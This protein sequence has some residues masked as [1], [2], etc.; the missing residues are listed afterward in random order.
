M[1]WLHPRLEMLRRYAH[2][3]V[4][5]S[6]SRRLTRHLA[7]CPRCRADVMRL[8]EIR[9]LLRQDPPGS[10]PDVLA[11]VLARRAAGERLLIPDVISCESG[12][13]SMRM[14]AAAAA[15]ILACGAALVFVGSPV[16]G[17]APGELRFVPEAP[18]P[19]AEIEVS[20]RPGAALAHHDSVVLRGRLRTPADVAYG[21][22]D[23]QRRVAVLRRQ[24][25]GAFTGT[26]RLPDSV[27]YAVFAVEDA[28]GEVIDS[29]YRR[30]WELEVH[31]ADGRV[32]FE[33]LEQRYREMHGRSW[34]GM[35]ES[36]RS[37][38]EQY[39]ED[40]RGW[41]S[42]SLLDAKVAPQDGR[43]SDAVSDSLRRTHFHA[44]L[45]PQLS[46]SADV[47]D[48]MAGYAPGHMRPYWGERLLREAPLHPLSLLTRENR[49]WRERVDYPALV[50]AMWREAEAVIDPA[51]SPWIQNVA[52]RLGGTGDPQLALRW[53][54]RYL[55]ISGRSAANT[56]NQ[57]ERLARR[58]ELSETVLRMALEY[59]EWTY[60]AGDEF[61]ALHTPRS[62]FTRALARDR[63]STLGIAA[64][65]MLVLGDTAAALRTL[66]DATADGWN[67][68]A[69]ALAA[70]TLLATGDTLGAL[71]QWALAATEPGAEAYADTARI[72]G[73][74]HFAP[75]A[76]SEW[77]AGARERLRRVLYAES[78][79][80]EIW[81]SIVLTDLEGRM[82]RFGELRDS[83][84]TVLV[85]WAP[86]AA[87]LLPNIER[88]AADVAREYDVAFLTVAWDGTPE[89]VK[90]SVGATGFSLP[91]LL[92]T[93]R[94]ARDLFNLFA[95]PSFAVIDAAGMVRF[96]FTDVRTLRRH[97]A[98]IAEPKVASR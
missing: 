69:F 97:I 48:A 30:F 62:V 26:F 85:F 67:P 14:L 4:T 15:L 9:T 50:E 33:A 63:R 59:A 71:R 87:P 28:D 68:A 74:R 70:N 94:E 91:V 1:S 18:R 84:A 76:W 80:R 44:R 35:L 65:R 61:R 3:D 81:R 20:Y 54:E 23:R 21:H 64:G 39:P 82:H 12:G 10:A 43:A 19:G 6:A 53:A 22:H 77:S 88:I 52:T 89:Q 58:P 66:A 5:L 40:P 90:Q 32:L 17:T 95:F 92:D 96:E 83:R 37:M 56:S 38:T 75:E 24:R 47:I 49:A 36:A 51:H 25:D 27:V 73:G 29:N 78:T 93:R 31:G 86:A 79:P 72:R 13:R 2:D 98:A 8:R 41:R 57:L 7:R 42:L 11:T 55:R 60:A 16:H 46:L 45:A 34:D